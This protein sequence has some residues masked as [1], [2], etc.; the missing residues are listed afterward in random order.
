M[1]K[2]TTLPEPKQAPDDSGAEA[3]RLGI[4]RLPRSGEDLPD[5]IVAIARTLGVLPGDARIDG[6]HKRG[7]TDELLEVTP[8]ALWRKPGFLQDVDHRLVGGTL[9]FSAGDVLAL[10][11]GAG[12][13]GADR[14][15]HE[16]RQHGLDVG[17]EG[18]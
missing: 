8:A 2:S 9:H 5:N 16:L 11:S 1:S 18:G 13:A 10:R 4:P 15:E 17:L 6:P 14:L 7:L 12:S 3:K